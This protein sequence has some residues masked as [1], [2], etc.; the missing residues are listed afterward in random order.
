MD[1]AVEIASRIAVATADPTEDLGSLRASYSQMRRVC[2]YVVVGRSIPLQRVLLRWIQHG[3]WNQ[4]YDHEYHT[5]LIAKLASV[6]NPEAY[7]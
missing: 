2:G 7:F 3:T 6:E 5:K 4:F 1:V